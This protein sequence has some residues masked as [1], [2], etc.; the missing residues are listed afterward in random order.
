MAETLE[1]DRKENSQEG[2]K[3]LLITWKLLKTTSATKKKKNT[4]NNKILRSAQFLTYNAK[5]I[6]LFFDSLVNFFLCFVH[7]QVQDEWRLQ[8]FHFTFFRK[9]TSSISLFYFG[10]LCV[11]KKIDINCP[12]GRNQRWRNISSLAEA[13][14]NQWWELKKKTFL[15]HSKCLHKEFIHL[16]CLGNTCQ[17]WWKCVL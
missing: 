11:W 8:Q 2:L 12:R 13:S 9:K 7:F 5:P 1:S 17:V 15:Q 16:F 10:V 6:L 3:I 14:K 4:K